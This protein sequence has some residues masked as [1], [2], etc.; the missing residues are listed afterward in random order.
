MPLF[1]PSQDHRVLIVPGLH[2]SGPAHWQSRWEHSNPWFERVEQECWDVPDLPAWSLAVSHGIRRSS[3][4]VILVC[5]SFGCLA[6]IHAWNVHRPANLAGLLLVAPADPHK[7][8]LADDSLLCRPSFPA[9]VAA[10]RNDPWIDARRARYFA[11]VWGAEYVALGMLGH[12]NADSGLREWPRG[13]QLLCSLLART[14]DAGG[15]RRIRR[16][17]KSETAAPE[18]TAIP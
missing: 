8:G 9:I 5:H 3:R 16:L 18:L 12:V 7:F 11:Y 15:R 13:M 1:S 4:P 6:A 14:G 17:T 10:S 2:G